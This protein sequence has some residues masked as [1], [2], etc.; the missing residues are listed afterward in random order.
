MSNSTTLL[1]TIASNQ[2]AKEV[3]ANAL[4]DAASP[5]MIW[6][7]HASAC[8]GLT[9]GYYGGTYAANSISNGTLTLT[10]STTNYVYGDNATGAVS[11]NTTGVPSGKIPLY[12]IVTGST[13]VTSYT[14][15]RSYLPASQ[16]GS[17]ASALSGLSDVNVTEGPGING[18]SLTWNNSTGKWVAT[19][20]SGGGG[21][22]ALSGLSDVS[23]SEGSGIDGYVLRWKNSV[24]FWVAQ[25]LALG[26]TGVTSAFDPA[27]I[28]ANVTLSNGNLTATTTN[29]AW[30]QARATLPQTTG[31]LY[32][33]CTFVNIGTVGN[34]KSEFG[35][36]NGAAS[37][38]AGNP[39]GQDVNAYM[40]FSHGD[41]TGG[42]FYNGGTPLTSGFNLVNGTVLG[43][44]LDIPNKKVWFYNP[45][46][47]KWNNDVLANQNPATNTGGADLTALIAANSTLYLAG[48][49]QFN[50][51][52]P[53]ITMN[54]GSSAFSNTIPSGF[55]PWAALTPTL[56]T[57]VSISAPAAGQSLSYNGTAWTNTGTPY[58][59][60]M[61]C[62][63][64]PSNSLDM[65]RLVIPRAMTLP[66]SL[67]GSYA[68]ADVAATGS[69]TLTLSKN[70]SSIGTVNFAASATTGTFTFSSAV[71][72]AAGDILKLVNQSTAD[73]T[74]ANIS[75]SLVGSR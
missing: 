4:F 24:S 35:I 32:A 55:S 75:V 30:Q 51:T 41:A 71:T 13:S 48:G 57:D 9:W 21:A 10:A 61:Y 36:C 18:Y 67:T 63:G 7:R 23:V 25:A 64:V 73:A 27:H 12:A 56:L 5:A 50:T 20:V 54:G 59:M 33:E 17:G 19:N 15:L 44:A 34:D 66:A 29:T 22:T 2:A 14:D 1:D 28:S 31:K 3:V 62:P 49:V 72:F 26:P 52:S 8:S 65:A 46:I 43:V 68:S 74:L 42:T 58:D 37:T 6:G 38:V 45:I 47:G 16:G 69:T 70:G 40:V 39:F 60:L 53:V 11:V